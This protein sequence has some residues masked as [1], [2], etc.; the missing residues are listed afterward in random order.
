[1]TEIPLDYPSIL[2]QRIA[3]NDMT[4]KDAV[5]WLGQHG[6]KREKIKEFLK[7]EIGA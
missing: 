5:R 3:E 7:D 4:P 6:V 2:K 1:M